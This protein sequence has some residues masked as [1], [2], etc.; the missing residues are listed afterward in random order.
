MLLVGGGG[1]GGGRWQL[2]LDMSV[3]EHGLADVRVD[4]VEV[5]GGGRGRARHC[6]RL[7]VAEQVVEGARTR[8]KH[9]VCIVHRSAVHEVVVAVVV[10][11]VVIAAGVEVVVVVVVVAVR[12]TRR[13][14]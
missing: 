5:D 6:Q 12:L 13:E 14:Q 2:L 3:A 8:H 11:I 10:L 9:L 7:V 1:G 4:A